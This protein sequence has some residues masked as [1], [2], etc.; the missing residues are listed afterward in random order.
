MW[1]RHWNL[2][3]D[4]FTE[5]APAFI[6]IPGH[7]EAV[8]RL[9][10]GVE[11]GRGGCWLVGGWGLGKSTILSRALDVLRQPN[12]RVAR[13]SAAM[14]ETAL[15]TELA[16]QL[17]ARVPEGAGRAL[18]WRKLA[19]ATRLCRWQGL[20][21][22]IAIDEAGE[23]SDP[24]ELSLI[25]HLDPHP[26]TRLTVL[27]VARAPDSASSIWEPTI[28]LAPLTR[29][30]AEHYL[31]LKLAA[32]DGEEPVFTSR[33]LSRLHAWSGGVPRALDRLAS[34][35]LREGARRGLALIGPDVVESVATAGLAVGSSP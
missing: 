34:L 33:A 29:G 14:G 13:A 32:V 23:L 11:S 4:P 30:E 20:G 19:E 16:E 2:R 18:A 22:V 9:V 15:L 1:L 35:C 27:R 25:H 3:H 21:I 28:R 10:D 12:R 26:R 31:T 5:P 7:T 8:A 6:A 24:L 17:G